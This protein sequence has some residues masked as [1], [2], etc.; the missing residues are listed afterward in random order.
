M[1]LEGAGLGQEAEMEEAVLE[2]GGRECRREAGVGVAETIQA[3]SPP[4]L[5]LEGGA[6]TG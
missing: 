4:N 2:V 3:L 6:E 5:C 1:F